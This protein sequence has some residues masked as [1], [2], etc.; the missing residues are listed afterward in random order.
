MNGSYQD[1][2]RPLNNELRLSSQ[3]FT[4]RSPSLGVHPSHPTYVPLLPPPSLRSTAQKKKVTTACLPSMSRW[5]RIFACPQPLAGRQ[6]PPSRLSHEG[7]LQLSLD[8][9]IH[10]LDK[11]PRHCTP[12]QFCKCSRQNSSVQWTSLNPNPAAFSELHSATDLALHAIKMPAHAA[13]P[14]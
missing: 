3:R 8:K 9:T 7:L 6:K 12:W 10:R 14:W 11:W 1:A 13:D 2:V 4:T 5:T